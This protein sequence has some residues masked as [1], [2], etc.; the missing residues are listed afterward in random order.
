MTL[1]KRSCSLRD[2]GVLEGFDRLVGFLAV[3]R[4]SGS[5]GCLEGF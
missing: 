2:L 4:G 3:L 1:R 5:L